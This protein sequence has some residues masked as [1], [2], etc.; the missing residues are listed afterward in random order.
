MSTWISD[1]VRPGRIAPAVLFV[2]AGCD[3]M[4]LRM[5]D[6]PTTNALLAGGEI[7]LAGPP[8]YCIDAESLRTGR[9]GGFALLASCAALGANAL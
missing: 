7:Q 4:P 8:G 3:A 6:A 2:V 1:R 9:T 5:D